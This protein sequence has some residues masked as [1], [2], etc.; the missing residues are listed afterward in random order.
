MVAMLERFF[1]E[2]MSSGTERE[3]GGNASTAAAGPAKL[4]VK[5]QNVVATVSLGKTHSPSTM[6]LFL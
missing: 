5:I 3:S 4:T 1:A 6:I 2:E